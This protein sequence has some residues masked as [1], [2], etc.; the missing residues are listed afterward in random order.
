MRHLFLAAI[1][2]AAST[3]VSAEGKPFPVPSDARATYFILEVSG[4][5]P[6]RTIVTK[7]IGSSGTSYSK[8]LYDCSN[9][10]VKY[11]GTGD[12]MAEMGNSKPDPKM[13]PIVSQSIADYVGRQ[14]CI[15]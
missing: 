9:A 4:N 14:A 6:D 1:M 5:W 13:S 10:T 8:R 2:L 11:L 15:R 7:R 3:L 12:T